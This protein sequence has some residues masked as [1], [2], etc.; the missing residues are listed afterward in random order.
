[1]KTFIDRGA[2]HFSILI[3]TTRCLIFFIPASDL[4]PPIHQSV[5]PIQ[6]AKTHHQKMIVGFLVSRRVIATI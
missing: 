1:V 2:D 3:L 4:N 6:N 5:K